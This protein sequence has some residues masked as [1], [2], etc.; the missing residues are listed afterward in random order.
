MPWQ[1]ITCSFSG[2][3]I[4]GE[5]ILASAEANGPSLFAWR[6][7]FWLIVFIVVGWTSNQR[8]FQ[9]KLNY[10][11]SIVQKYKKNKLTRKR[12]KAINFEPRYV[13]VESSLKRFKSRNCVASLCSAFFSWLLLCWMNALIRN[14]FR[15]AFFWVIFTLKACQRSQHTVLP[16]VSNEEPA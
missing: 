9:Q 1:H 6:G 5:L 13:T 15:C 8:S 4:H 2:L 11:A 7:R 16:W 3:C 10:S 14:L 12:S